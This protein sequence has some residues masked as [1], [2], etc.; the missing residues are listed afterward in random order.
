MTR[1]S[2][3]LSWLDEVGGDKARWQAAL[4]DTKKCQAEALREDTPIKRL[5]TFYRCRKGKRL[6]PKGL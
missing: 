2:D 5:R 1:L 6:A 3:F 4:E